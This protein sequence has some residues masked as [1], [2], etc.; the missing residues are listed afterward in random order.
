MGLQKKDIGFKKFMESLEGAQHAQFLALSTTKVKSPDHFEKM[1]QH[2]LAHYSGIEVASSFEDPNGQVWDCVPVGQQPSLKEKGRRLPVPPVLVSPPTKK[3]QQAAARG[4]LARSFLSNAKK[5]RYGNTLF[6]SPGFIPIRR[7]TLDELMKFETLDKFL[8]K[9]PRS[10]LA[11]GNAPLEADT[12]NEV[13]KYA[14][15]AQQV[16]NVGGHSFLNIWQPAIAGD[17][18][19]SLSQHW[20]I[21]GDGTQLQTVEAGWQV[22][23]E[24]YGTPEPCLFIYYT[25]DNYTTGC[26]NLDSAAF[27]QTSHK[28]ALGGPLSGQ[29]SSRDGDQ[30][31][32]E[33]SWSLADGNWWLFINGLTPDDAVGYYPATLYKGG[34]L[35]S[36]ATFIDYGGE[37]VGS[38]SWPEMGSG[39]FA[40]EGD[41]KAAYQRSI[42]YFDTTGGSNWASLSP[43]QDFPNCFTIDPGE[44]N[45]QGPFFYFGGPGGNNC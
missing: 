38:S 5:D 41:K 42:N 18:V 22:Y 35:A 12:G 37:T 2:L 26:Y 15:A 27:V 24:K 17:Q 20:Y 19:F 9:S 16:D 23:P 1:R 4:Q 7:T 10:N 3:T 40:G 33:I 44:D 8:K 45:E 25:P 13:H 6:C 14:H 32:I 11:P 28:W 39:A 21:A 34:P 31:E 36:H 29:I 43:N 30:F